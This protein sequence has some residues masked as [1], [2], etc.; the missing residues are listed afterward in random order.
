MLFFDELIYECYSFKKWLFY[1]IGLN[2]LSHPYKNKTK[3]LIQEQELFGAGLFPLLAALSGSCGLAYEIIYVRL[4]SNYFGDSYIMSGIILS[5]VFLGIAFGAW[6][7]TRFIRA[8]AFIEIAIGLYAFS[9]VT[10]FSYWGFEIASFGSSAG[11]NALKL[12][13]LLGFPAFLIGTCVPLF[14]AYAQSAKMSESN[15]FPRIY[16]FYNLG[17]FL[18][19][20]AIEFILFR[21]LGILFTGIIIGCLNL[22]IG[23]VLLRTKASNRVNLKIKSKAPKDISI[24]TALFIASF[25]S[26]VFQLFVLRLSF[27][28]FGPLHENFAIILT[29]AILGVAIG[30]WAALGKR[31]SFAKALLCLSIG[32]LIFLSTVSLFIELWTFVTHSG[33]SDWGETLAKITLLGGYPLLI[34]IL[35]GSLVPLALKAH[36]KDTNTLSGPL[37]AISSLGNGLGTLFMFVVLYQYFSLL[38]IGGIITALLFL[39]FL[40]LSYRKNIRIVRAAGWGVA[41]ICFALASFYLWPRVELLLGYRALANAEQLEY[42]RANFKD[43]IIYKAYDQSVSLVSFNDQNTSLVINGY[44]SLTFGPQSK[45]VL[46]ETIVGTTASLF[47][48]DVNEALI[49]GLGTGITGGA[50][51]GIYEHTKIV[52]VN[53]AIFS[54]PQHFEQANKGVMHNSGVDV[55]LEDG[56][57]TLLTDPKTYDVIVN[58]VT[59]PQYYSAA[60]LYTQDFYEIVK[61]RLNEGGVYSS[62]FDLRID[63][64]GVSIML[65]T[66]EASFSACRYFVLGRAYFNVVCSDD[67]LTYRASKITNERIQDA[68]FDR[69]FQSYKFPGGFVDTMQALEVKFDTDFLTRTSTAINTL[70]LPAIEFVVARNND[71]LETSDLL[72]K[73]IL[74]NIEFQR[75]ISFG[76][77][78]WKFNCK[79]IGQ[80]SGLQ[81]KGC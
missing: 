2:D 40:I 21:Q 39:G 56:I 6:Q 51:A 49:F 61:M 36:D 11:F 68:G 55:V 63:R 3:T 14:T 10:A 80:M 18:S 5:A 12:I 26:G 78:N 29:S 47:S 60:K 44:G 52:E 42:K 66:L 13:L 53:P 43:A 57:S 15:V 46:H 50:T 67:A 58:T 27:S 75:K 65:N 4:F 23:A 19:V 35:F 54:I 71:I 30:S 25:A 74:A 77:S 69:L 22:C 1:R 76:N 72:G 64:A 48:K 79:I 24:F 59:S 41:G 17:A 62:W 73:A 7:S 38:F 20:L 9:A 32:V 28:V 81:F 8:L 31:L 70:D 16:A 33:L 45:S 34:F 37:L